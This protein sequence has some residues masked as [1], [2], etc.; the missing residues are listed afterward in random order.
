[1]VTALIVCALCTSA[2]A[3]SLD[4]LVARVVPTA[5]EDKWL[6][7]PWQTDLME[8]QKTAAAQNKP[9]FMWL[10]DGDPLGRT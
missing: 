6:S 1:M 10:M 3:T 5:E 4:A 8:A 2:P 7:I 9:V